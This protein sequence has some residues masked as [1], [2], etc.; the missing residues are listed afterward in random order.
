MIAMERKLKYWT[1]DIPIKFNSEKEAKR[2][3]KNLR[4][5]IADTCKSKG[6]MA[7]VMIGVSNANGKIITNEYNNRNGTIG[8]PEKNKNITN[9]K[10]VLLCERE[11]NPKWHIQFL[12]LSEPSETL[13]KLVKAYIKKKFYKGKKIDVLLIKEFNINIGYIFYVGRQSAELYYVGSTD[14][15]FNYT[16]KQLYN[17]KVKL[18]TAIRY[19]D[20]K[21]KIK[22]LNDSYNDMLNYFNSLNAEQRE[23]DRIKFLKKKQKE[24]I[25]AKY[26]KLQK[27]KM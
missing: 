2:L 25:R 6:Y 15:R 24:I 16:F 14:K 5:L 17:A 13:S 18:D 19:D 23:I 12:A 26:N 22:R 7:Q 27:N 8:R 11:L 20:S 1:I 9:E 21:V 3:A 10:I 4:Q